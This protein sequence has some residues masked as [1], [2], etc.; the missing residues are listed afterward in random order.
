MHL[1]WGCTLTITDQT[2]ILVSGLE[3]HAVIQG[4][5]NGAEVVSYQF[6]H[7]RNIE[8]RIKALLWIRMTLDGMYV[9]VKWHGA[10]FGWVP[11]HSTQTY[12]PSNF[13]YLTCGLRL[14]FTFSSGLG[15]LVLRYFFCSKH[16]LGYL[17]AN[18]SYDNL[19]KTYTPHISNDRSLTTLAKGDM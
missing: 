11:C 5:R 18:M 7:I 14:F 6:D 16:E 10:R 9:C 19:K 12:I 4:N 15:K 8:S 13:F 2:W 3:E 17:I 1:A